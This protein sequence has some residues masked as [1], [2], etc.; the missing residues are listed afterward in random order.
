[1]NWSN[2]ALILHRE[3]RDQLRDRRT[4]FMIAVLPLLLYPLLGMS[5]FQVFQFVQE[6]ATKVL[7]IGAA[8]LPD[9]PALLSDKSFAE[10]WFSDPQKSKLLQVTRDQDAPDLAGRFSADIARAATEAVERGDFEAVVYFSPGFSERLETFRAQLTRRSSAGAHEPST[11]SH[12]QSSGD[13]NGGEES[14][15]ETGTSL[16]GPNIY[17]NTAKQKSQITF[18][19][20]SR[21]I[22]R[23]RDAIGRDN[24]ALSQLPKSTARPFTWQEHDVAKDTGR[25]NAAVWSRLLPFLL[26]IWAL[27]G[28]F[29]PAIDLC[30]GEKERGTLETLLASPAERSEIVWGKLLTVVAFSAATAVLNLVSIGTTGAFVISVLPNEIGSPPPWAPLWLLLALAPMSALFSALCL[31]LAAF[32]KSSKEGQYY[33]MPLMLVT[34][35]LV[36]LPL[37]PGVE[38]TL[39]NSLIPVTGVVLLLRALLEGNYFNALPYVLTVVGVTLACCLWA[40]R[41]AVDQFNSE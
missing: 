29:Y 24:L 13:D 15:S 11:A 6:Q 19:R 36:V 7:V 22:D 8:E 38:L 34:M 18:D 35:P 31:A 10:R 28:A 12:E 21:V 1:M 16:P 9:S 33:L 41:W 32:A 5:L 40:V 39:G 2:V 17:Y 4:L 30:A 23:W 3:V 25:R 37:A 20:V 27:T 26:V 14:D